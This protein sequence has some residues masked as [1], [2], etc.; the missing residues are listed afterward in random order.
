MLRIIH[1]DHIN[2]AKYVNNNSI[3]LIVIEDT[4][5]AEKTESYSSTFSKLEMTFGKCFKPYVRIAVITQEFIPRVKGYYPQEVVSCDNSPYFIILLGKVQKLGLSLAKVQDQ[6]QSTDFS[7]G[8]PHQHP[9]WVYRHLV[10]RYGERGCIYEA[11]MGSGNCAVA[12]WLE[13]PQLNYVGFEK[14]DKWVNII[15]KRLDALCA[16]YHTK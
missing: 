8:H 13:N 6:W 2:T 14:E 5:R 12:C 3:D 11:G 9:L 10:I 16:E 4:F 1:D 15:H 7:T